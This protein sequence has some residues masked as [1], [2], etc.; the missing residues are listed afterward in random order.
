[1]GQLESFNPA[2]GELVGSVETLKPDQVQAVVD[3]VAEVQP[4]WAQLTLADRARYLRRAADVLVEELDE[5]AELLT[6]EQGKP[7]TESYTMEVVPTIDVLHWCADAGPE[8]PRRRADP[9]G[10]GPVPVEEGQVQLR[11]ARASSA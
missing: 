6:R 9:H 2:T 5:V 11:A 4:F 8:D 1:M 10:P 7:I 3:D